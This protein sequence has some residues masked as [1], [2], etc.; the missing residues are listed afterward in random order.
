M[1]HTHLLFLDAWR[2]LALHRADLAI[3]TPTGAWRQVLDRP[4]D[5][6]PIAWAR[7]RNCN[8]CDIYIRPARGTPWPYIFLDDLPKP[9]ACRLI[10][11]HPGIAIHTSFAGGCQVWLALTSSIHE[12]Q[13]TCLQ[14]SLAKSLCADPAS[15]SGEH[16]GR[17]A[18]LRNW[19]RHGTWISLLATNFQAQPLDLDICD[20]PDQTPPSAS[21]PNPIRTCDGPDHSDSAREWGWV[22]GAI[23]HGL[24]IDLIRQRLHQQAR[25]R[26]HHDT[27]RYVE[28]TVRNATKHIARN[29]L[30]FPPQ[31]RQGRGSKPEHPEPFP[32][33][34]SQI[35]PLVAGTTFGNDPVSNH[36]HLS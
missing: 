7:A 24:P 36:P 6:L 21:L 26:R 31:G 11:K 2:R 5:Q 35:P 9:I 1:T 27:D 4:L 20:R 25:T 13:R 29:H 8:H 19:K 16:Y 30:V 3:R 10:A 14:R 18:G 17:L 22:C 32:G 33:S 12:H 23:E 28:L 15:I 34:R